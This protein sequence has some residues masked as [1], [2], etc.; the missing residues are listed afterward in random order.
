MVASIIEKQKLE[1]RYAYWLDEGPQIDALVYALYGL[2][3]AA[4]RE[5]ELWYC[6]RYERL[7]RAQGVWETVAHKYGLSAD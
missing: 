7:A 6:R 2:D 4:I 5:V 3:E 1:P